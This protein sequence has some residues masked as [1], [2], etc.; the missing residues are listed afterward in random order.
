MV[1]AS[2]FER[3]WKIV[4]DGREFGYSYNSDRTLLFC[5]PL[6]TSEEIDLFY[7]TQFNY[8]WYTQRKKLKKIQG[9]HRWKFIRHF[10]KKCARL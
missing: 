1:S 2:V 6:P 4:Q 10:L 5:N 9:W 7:R 3:K 8:N